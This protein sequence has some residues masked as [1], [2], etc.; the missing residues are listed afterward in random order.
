MKHFL[1]NITEEELNAEIKQTEE[2]WALIAGHD[3]KED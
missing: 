1:E 3:K 2:D